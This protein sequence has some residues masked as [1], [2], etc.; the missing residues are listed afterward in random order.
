MNA[1]TID[2]IDPVTARRQLHTTNDSHMEWRY[3]NINSRDTEIQTE[4]N[5]DNDKQDR[6]VIRFHQSC[7]DKGDDRKSGE[8]PYDLLLAGIGSSS[9]TTLVV[10][11]AKI[12][13][14]CGFSDLV[15]EM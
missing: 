4:M 15:P 13:A 7:V 1:V 3:T 5:V 9:T 12:K 2:A 6:I 14:L 10:C 11:M 8:S